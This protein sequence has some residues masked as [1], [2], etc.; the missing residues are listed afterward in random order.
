MKLILLASVPHSGTIFMQEFI[1]RHSAI[2]N[3]T[4][5]AQ[6]M[7]NTSGGLENPYRAQRGLVPGTTNLV[8]SHIEHYTLDALRAYCFHVPTVIPVRD[9]LLSIVTRKK[10]RPEAHHVWMVENW[11]IL[12]TFIW[13]Y[14]TAAYYPVDLENQKPY[15]ERRK[16][17]LQIAE[18]C[19]LEPENYMDEYAQKFAPANTRGEYELKTM[20]KEGDFEQLKLHLKPEIQQLQANEG[21]LRPMLEE[22]GYENLMW[23][24]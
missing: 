10:R 12:R 18:H 3:T 4:G 8:W 6:V 14:E 5:L 15:A 17:L 23:W 19:G 24:S 1:E 7:K 22:I 2:G 13:P 21:V 16:S 9:P 20:Y 11:L